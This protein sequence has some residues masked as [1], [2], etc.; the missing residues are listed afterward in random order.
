[1]SILIWKGNRCA[2]PSLCTGSINAK[3]IPCYPTAC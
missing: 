3:I 2:S 1:L